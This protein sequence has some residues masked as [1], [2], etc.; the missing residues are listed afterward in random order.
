MVR[1]YHECNFA[2]QGESTALAVGMMGS[3]KCH[4]G[5]NKGCDCVC[6][7]DSDIDGDCTKG[8]E[9]S[10]GWTLFKFKDLVKDVSE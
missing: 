7:P 8:Q 10:P 4:T 6:F 9:D 3:D 5:E 2:C 1:S